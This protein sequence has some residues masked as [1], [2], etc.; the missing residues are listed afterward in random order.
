MPSQPRAI[1]FYLPQYHP[2]PLNDR[3]WGPGFTEWTNVRA[4]QPLFWRHDQPHVPAE[5]GYYSLLDPRTRAAQAE[6]ARAHGVSGFCYYHYWFA[7]ERLLERP[8]DEVLASGEPDFPFC[9]CWANEPWTRHWDGHSGEILM[10]QRYSPE[11]DTRHIAWLAHVLQDARYIRVD[12]KPIVL[13]YRATQLP[14]VAATLRVW[15][16]FA[17]EH[18]IG[19]LFLCRVESFAEERD[20]PHQYGF[21]AAVEF[22]PDC[23]NIGQA[24]AAV[25]APRRSSVVE[26]ADFS[27]LQMRKREPA[28]RRFRCV[29]PRWDNTPRNKRWPFVL[30]HSSPELYERWLRAAVA[31]ER[32]ANAA[33]PIVFINAWNEWGEGNHLEPDIRWGRAYLEATA[34]ALAAP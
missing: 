4:A 32:H 14:D 11:D 7:G 28:Y 29:V 20:D 6:L 1:A 13:I 23:I 33:D 21:D 26:Y 18:G 9:V 27:E 3:A 34:R 15:R 16:T 25:G 8:L 12:G 17:R 31:A 24:I 22:Q 10:P 5:L 2:I 19:E 30:H